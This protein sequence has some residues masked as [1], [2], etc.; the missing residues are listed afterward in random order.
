MLVWRLYPPRTAPW[1]CV[2]STRP[3]R[4]HCPPTPGLYSCDSCTQWTPQVSVTQCPVHIKYTGL[5]IY[6]RTEIDI[7]HQN[8]SYNSQYYY[9]NC[10]VIDAVHYYWVSCIGV[11]RNCTI[12]NSI[13]M[14][15]LCGQITLQ[16]SVLKSSIKCSNK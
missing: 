4:R 7:F 11:S 16:L 14:C 2:S 10:R 1:T 6:T 3:S 9:Q 8:L 13:V 5:N 15:L 12:S